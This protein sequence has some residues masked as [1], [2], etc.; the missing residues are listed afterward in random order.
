MMWTTCTLRMNAWQKYSV[1]GHFWQYQPVIRTRPFHTTSNVLESKAEREIEIATNL[2]RKIHLLP[3]KK[4]A[5][6]QHWIREKWHL[7]QAL[8][9]PTLR[10][11]S[12][13]EKVKSKPVDEKIQTFVKDNNLGKVRHI[14]ILAR[15]QR[16]KPLFD[17][18]E[19]TPA[20]KVCDDIYVNM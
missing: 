9:K 19:K 14:S 13:E 7:R 15:H 10:V 17:T 8:M 16:G 1:T 12:K 11:Q 3:K 18:K 5:L 20:E 6:L 4:Q 2:L